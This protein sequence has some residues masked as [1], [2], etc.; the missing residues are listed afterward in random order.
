MVNNM[1]EGGVVA[2]ESFRSFALP[3]LPKSWNPLQEPP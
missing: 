1:L 2:G 3:D